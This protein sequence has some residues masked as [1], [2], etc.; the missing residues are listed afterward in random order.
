MLAGLI[1]LVIVQQP[2]QS[3]GKVEKNVNREYLAIRREL[4]ELRVWRVP[5]T[6]A[7]EVRVER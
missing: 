5:R 4:S 1:T 2:E 7:Q 6:S 3:S